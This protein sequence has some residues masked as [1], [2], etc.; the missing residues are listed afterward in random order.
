MAQIVLDRVEKAYAGGVRA[1][2]DLSLD[3]A[4]GEFMVFVGP[5]GCGKSTALRS[6]AGHRVYR[7]HGAV[8][9][10]GS[11]FPGGLLLDG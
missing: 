9:R 1:V 6:I 5:S 2:D 8:L 3:I 11:P 10:R 7:R 4:D